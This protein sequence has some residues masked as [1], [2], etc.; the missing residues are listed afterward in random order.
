MTWGFCYLPEAAAG[1]G[2]GRTAVAS[3]SSGLWRWFR[4]GF[5]VPAPDGFSATVG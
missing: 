4:G 3:L 5:G 2:A 1:A